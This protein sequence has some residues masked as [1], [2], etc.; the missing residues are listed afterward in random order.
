[1]RVIK[2]LN[3][4]LILSEDENQHEIIVM[5]KGIGFKSKTGELI[6]PAS[7]EKVFV[8][9]NSVDTKE[10]IRILENMPKQHLN[11]INQALS[12]VK[13]E[14][15]GYLNDRT[16][17]MLM[18]HIAFAI[19][20]FQKGITLQNKLLWEVQKFY[21]KEYE[22]GL[23][24]LKELN[25]VLGLEMP[26]EE[27]GNIAFHLVNAQS[28]KQNMESTMISI[29]LLKDILNLVQYQLKI[30]IDSNS[31][32]YTRF[33]THLQYFIQRLLDD[34]QLKTKDSFIYTQTKNAYNE[35]YTCAE[36]I[37]SYVRNVID[38]DITD[39]EVLYLMIHLIRMAG[40]EE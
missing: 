6:D 38:L 37:R 36:S 7:V 14:L 16:F 34:K 27:A 32:R 18:D 26:D 10:Y 23:H 1:M 4:S 2:I 13:H 28:D 30:S 22:I 11:A 20:R 9:I 21:P 5:G 17:I 25:G 33:V 12:S 29:K 3:N 39:E 8:P 40:L 15:D 35:E 24:I 19:E 31:I